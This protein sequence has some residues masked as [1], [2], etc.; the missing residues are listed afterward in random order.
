MD[1]S[2]AQAQGL[3]HSN[4]PPLNR[5]SGWNFC[6]YLLGRRARLRVDGDSMQPALG[7]GQEVLVKLN[8]F[9][10][11]P[12]RLGD[13]VYLRHPLRKDTVMF[14]RIAALEADGRFR[15]LG[16]NAAASTDSRQ[17]GAVKREHIKGKVICTFP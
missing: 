4:G 6:L 13:L 17:F 11:D 2:N 16:D 5:L 14:K 1:D 8:A 7:S 3:E 15:V 10:R 9:D 12:P